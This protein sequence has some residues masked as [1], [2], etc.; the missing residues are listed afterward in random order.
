M[1][2]LSYA[3][4]IN[5]A[6]REEMERDP[7]TFVMGQDVGAFGGAFGITRG[8]QE[9]FGAQRVRDTPI[10]ENLIAGAAVGAALTGTRPI[11][12]LQYADFIEVAM[13]E[14]YNKAAKWRYMHGGLQTVP[15]VLRAPSG[16][17][18][19]AGPEHSQ[20]PESLLVSASGLHVLTPSTAND[21]RGLLKAAIRSDDPVIYFEHKK[22]Y[23][24]KSDV[25]EG[26]DV[27]PIGQANVVRP[28]RD[29]TIV[30]W[31]VMVHEA[32]AAAEILAEQRGIEAEV[33]DP[34]GIRPI[35]YDR[36]FD[37]V[38]KTGRLVVAHESPTPG[39]VAS[40]VSATVSENIIEY[41]AAPVIRACSADVPIPQST[42]L[43]ALVIPNKDSII[44]AVQRTLL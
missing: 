22:L 44:E 26:D 35:D 32:V 30:A 3:R 4:A 17:A 40:E 12:E 41:L 16:A 8:L 25:S 15:M 34:R 29:V 38:K 36:I 13:D 20:C 42:R 23:G 27:I 31:Q 1:P 6:L 21:A 19:G 10:S 5:Q 11:V 28:G 43:E 14:I 24:R 2:T 9:K 37:S 7:R 39:S 18:N 33:I